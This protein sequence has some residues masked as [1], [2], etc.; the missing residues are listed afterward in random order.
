MT[1]TNHTPYTGLEDYEMNPKL[2]EGGSGNSV[3]DNYFVTANYL[4]SSVKDFFDYLKN[5][6]FMKNPLLFF[7]VITTEFL[8]QIQNTTPHSLVKVQITGQSMIIQ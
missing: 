5:L 7:T 1:V 8:V 3:V 6:D 4:D 2:L